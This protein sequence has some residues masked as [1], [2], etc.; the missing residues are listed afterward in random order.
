MIQ[1][2]KDL[3]DYAMQ[4]TIPLWERAQRRK[5]GLLTEIN[6]NAGYSTSWIEN[7][8]RPLWGIAPVLRERGQEY[9]LRADGCEEPLIPWIRR[10]VVDGTNP[11]SPYYWDRAGRID[12][13]NVVSNQV[14]TE[15]AGLLT[16]FYFAREVLWDPLKDSE[17]KQI[18]DWIFHCTEVAFQECYPNNHYWFCVL[19]FLILKKLG[20][21]YRNTEQYIK[22]GLD[23]LDELYLGNGWYKDGEFGRFDYYIPWALHSYPLLWT[24]MEDESFGGY[25]ERKKKYIERTNEFLP[26]YAHCFD[27]TGSH[28]PFGRSLSYRYAASGIFPLAVFA[29]CDFD[30]GLARN[31]VLKNINYFAENMSVRE[32]GILPPGF[33]YSSPGVIENYT[34]DG[35]PYWCTKAFW[36]LFLPEDHAFWQAPLK[37][38]P[39]EQGPYRENSGHE[40]IHMLTV[41]EGE[42]NGVTLYNN[43][44]SYMQHG[45]KAHFFNDLEGYY[46]KFAYN[47][48]SGFGLS[49]R[50]MVSLDNMIGLV[51]KDR[52]MWSH[53]MGFTDMGESNGILESSHVPFSND[54]GTVIHTWL[55]PLFGGWHVRIHK[56]QMA[57][58]YSIVEGGFSV[59]LRTDCRIEKAD[60]QEASVEAGGL[61]S[62]IHTHS[63]VPVHFF[64]REVQPGMHLLQ[65]FALYPCYETQEVC[66]AGNYFFVS[67]FGFFEKNGGT[68]A[69]LIHVEEGQVTVSHQGMLYQ[70]KTERRGVSI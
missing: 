44:A 65:P 57:R 41:G 31:M 48:R 39:I 9:M 13:S 15:M 58:P 46:S 53:R 38:L 22:A 27:K 59:G 2:R 18:A 68:P 24:L 51:T 30:P 54:P 14:K 11:Q 10:T 60:V 63:S 1:T 35:G 7:F 4:I 66:P 6:D 42:V 52:T 49:T 50:D 33:L 64:V 12:A 19:N 55:L 70:I 40:K 45:E 37:P 28:I 20:F 8:C 16:G 62:V 5:K 47:S 43:T 61:Y 23:K 21:S 26:R 67:S 29:G 56:V 36:A 32:D 69:P 3:E 34:S 17:K 25:Q